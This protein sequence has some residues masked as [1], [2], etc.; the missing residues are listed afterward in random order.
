[1]SGSSG[2]AGLLDLTEPTTLLR[3][4]L[5]TERDP[6]WQT[7]GPQVGEVARALGFPLHPWQQYVADIALEYRIV[8]GEIVFHYREVRLFV[9]RQSGKTVLMLALMAWRCMFAPDL[10]GKPQGVKFYSTSGTHAIAKWTDEHV[11]ALERSLLRDQFTVRR[12]N[13]HQGF[14]WT[15]GSL[16]SLGSS[17]DKSGHGDSLDLVVADEF[18]SQDDDR[19]E[20]GARPT[21]ITRQCPQIWIVST[22][23]GEKETASGP[24]WKKVD[25]SRRRCRSG[26]HGSVASFEWSAADYESAAL[27]IG[28]H[29]LWLRTC[30]GLAENGGLKFY[31]LEALQAEFEGMELPA[32]RRAFLNLR[33]AKKVRNAPAVISPEQWAAVVDDRYLAHP[34][35]QLILGIG[36]E[37]DDSE[38]SIVVVGDALNAVDREDDRERAYLELAASQE[39]SDWVLDRLDKMIQRHD[40]RRVAVDVGG[41]AGRLL[42]GLKKLATRRKVKLIE[43]NGKAW[44]AACEDF[45]ISVRDETVVNNGSATLAAAVDQGIRRDVGDLWI[46]DL[47]AATAP[48]SSLIAATVGLRAHREAKITKRRSAYEEEDG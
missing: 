5:G 14:K 27:D 15:N 20:S 3:P 17:T 13:G 41:P 30:P 23:G 21:M 7:F 11:P 6:T 22:F 26:D 12:N 46:W 39:G 28:S 44:A 10:F 2:S 47:K 16:W 24:L 37:R 35:S 42:P 48:V 9:P 31:N 45:R 43:Y 8:D 40:V 1:M 33:P 18:F 4:R 25:D 38:S 19:I 36:V 29:E 34:R 32:F